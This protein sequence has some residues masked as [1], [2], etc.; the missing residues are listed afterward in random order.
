MD[1]GG[2]DVAFGGSRDPNGYAYA[3]MLG[4]PVAI[5]LSLVGPLSWSANSKHLEQETTRAYEQ[6]LPFS[7]R[8][9]RR[10]HN[11]LERMLTDISVPNQ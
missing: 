8:M 3:T 9:Q 11:Q 2:Y 6:R 4:A 7:K 1:I 5:T 10:L